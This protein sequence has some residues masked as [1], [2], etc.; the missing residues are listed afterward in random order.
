[1]GKYKVCGLAIILIVIIHA[2]EAAARRAKSNALR[3]AQKASPST[4]QSLKRP[5]SSKP[6]NFYYFSRNDAFGDKLKLR[7]I[8]RRRSS[9]ANGM[10]SFGLNL[11]EWLTDD[12]SDSHEIINP[13]D[14]LEFLKAVGQK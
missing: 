3:Q 13:T 5:F 9:P 2:C 1:M 4:S 6:T 14:S 11:P 10:G 8:R 7:W 12:L